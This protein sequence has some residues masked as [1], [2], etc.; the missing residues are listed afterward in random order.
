MRT[1]WA[2]NAEIV[3]V[4]DRC[5]PTLTVRAFAARLS[6]LNIR[7]AHASE[8]GHRK[9]LRPM[10]SDSY[11]FHRVRAARLAHGLADRQHDHVAALHV[12]SREQQILRSVQCFVAV[13]T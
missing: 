3:R 11:D 10:V 9:S 8:H 4:Y 5:S 12:R 6:S 13:G 7:C 1:P 2:P